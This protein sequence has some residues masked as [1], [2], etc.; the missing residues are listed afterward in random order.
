M[1]AFKTGTPSLLLSLILLLNQRIYAY[2]QTLDL[3][4]QLVI[5]SSKCVSKSFFRGGSILLGAKT[6]DKKILI[7]PSKFCFYACLFLSYEFFFGG[8]VG[9][10]NMDIPLNTAFAMMY[11]KV[12][13]QFLFSF[14]L[15][16]KFLFCAHSKSSDSNVK[17]KMKQG[18]L[19][20][21]LV[22]NLLFISVSA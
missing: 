7:T 15:P 6:K 9:G 14:Q 21:S 19:N 10:L 1:C 16:R 17:K 13:S 4:I 2:S 20:M 3:L 5:V 12:Y 22:T 11:L 18:I 8:G